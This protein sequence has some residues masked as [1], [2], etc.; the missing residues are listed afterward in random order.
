VT[1]H[2]YDLNFEDDLGEAME[3]QEV[4]Q[5]PP[6]SSKPTRYGRLL[7]VEDETTNLRLDL[8]RDEI[9]L[10]EDFQRQLLQMEIKLE[11]DMLDL[12]TLFEREKRTLVAHFKNKSIELKTLLERVP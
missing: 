1:E 9:R 2:E 12:R 4:Q 5:Q 10:R 3:S 11:R 6:P 7:D 8:A